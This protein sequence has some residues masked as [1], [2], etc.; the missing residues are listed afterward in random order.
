MGIGHK[1]YVEPI[2][3]FSGIDLGLARRRVLAMGLLS[4]K[5]VHQGIP[6]AVFLSSIEE[7]R[8]ALREKEGKHQGNS[9][10]EWNENESPL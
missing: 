10:G 2:R 8:S 7:K 5:R 1:T 4:Q 6:E 9:D 3:V